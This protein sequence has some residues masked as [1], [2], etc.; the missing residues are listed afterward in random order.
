MQGIT[1]HGVTFSS[2]RQCVWLCMQQ[3]FGKHSLYNLVFTLEITFYLV[4]LST[5]TIILH[6]KHIY[7][8]KGGVASYF[9]LLE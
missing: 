1:P 8:L 2:A 7:Q 6:N 3:I 5:C 4:S 9:V